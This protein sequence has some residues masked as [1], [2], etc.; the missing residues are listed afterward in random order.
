MTDYT[1]FDPEVSSLSIGNV[2][3]GVDVGSYPLARSFT[4]GVSLNY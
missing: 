2:N 4:F 1:G 3:R